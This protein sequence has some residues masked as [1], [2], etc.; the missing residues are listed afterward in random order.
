MPTAANVIESS[1]GGSPQ[2]PIVSQSA[3]SGSCSMSC[4]RR[5]AT[6]APCTMIHA[7]PAKMQ[8]GG[9]ARAPSQTGSAAA[10]EAA[11]LAGRG[12]QAGDHGAADEE[13]RQAAP[14]AAEVGRQPRHRDARAG[15]QPALGLVE[16][17]LRLAA[18]VE[19]PHRVGDRARVRAHDDVRDL[20]DP[21]LGERPQRS[22]PA[23]QPGRAPAVAVE[24]LERLDDE[25]VGVLEA[26][27]M[28]QDLAVG[29]LLRGLALARRG[30][31]Q[32][33]EDAL[34]VGVRAAGQ[35]AEAVE[36]RGEVVEQQAGA[37]PLAARA[38]RRA[39]QRRRR[40]TCA[41]PGRAFL[42]HDQPGTMGVRGSQP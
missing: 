11:H 25:V 42:T 19:P 7:T 5:W 20:L 38:R 22:E 34:G 29:E 3:S 39:R 26:I 2:A 15:E 27:G 16:V 14:A 8:R 4:E 6:A 17:A 1:R 30:G 18:R 40:D 37:R 41:A 36:L 35:E 31:R 9:R 10:R 33:G 32:P 21:D 13:A 28:G 12:D 24:D 23:R